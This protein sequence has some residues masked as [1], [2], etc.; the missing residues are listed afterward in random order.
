LQSRNGG[1]VKIYD[2][3]L[4]PGVSACRS[5]VPLKPVNGSRAVFQSKYKSLLVSERTTV[6]QLIRM[7]LDCCDS[8]HGV[9]RFSIYEVRVPVGV[10]PTRLKTH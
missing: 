6:D 3:E 10:G 2:G 8:E 4:T 7:L 9:E 5:R 1:L